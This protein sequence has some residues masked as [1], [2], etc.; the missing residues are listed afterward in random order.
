MIICLIKPSQL[1]FRPH[2]ENLFSDNKYFTETLVTEVPSGDYKHRTSLVRTP[3][4]RQDVFALSGVCINQYHLFCDML[5]TPVPISPLL[6]AV[7]TA[8]GY[9]YV[10]TSQL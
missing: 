2:G 5:N 7:D 4:D 8:T 6:I 9:M 3:G 1:L 10:S